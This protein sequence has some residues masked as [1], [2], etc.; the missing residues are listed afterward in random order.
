MPLQLR[1]PV[2]QVQQIRDIM[3]IYPKKNVRLLLTW[4]K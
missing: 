4:S 1:L 2:H 3:G